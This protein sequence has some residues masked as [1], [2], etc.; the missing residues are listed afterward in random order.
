MESLC[1]YCEP[2]VYLDNRLLCSPWCRYVGIYVLVH[3]MGVILPDWQ[4]CLVAK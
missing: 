3:K 1:S 2:L 4:W